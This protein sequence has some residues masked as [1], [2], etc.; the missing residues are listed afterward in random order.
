MRWYTSS[1]GR[2]PAANRVSSHPVTSTTLA[3]VRLRCSARSAQSAN[4]GVSCSVVSSQGN[5]ENQT[6]RPAAAAS[7]L[8]MLSRSGSPPE[9]RTAVHLSS[10]A[11]TCISR[12]TT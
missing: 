8:A 10:D 12:R 1:P 3:P 6:S 11:M 4:S 5:G 2:N 9:I 7:S